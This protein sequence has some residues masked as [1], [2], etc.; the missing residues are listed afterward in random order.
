MRVTGDLPILQINFSET[1]Y[2]A[3]MAAI[4]DVLETFNDDTPVVSSSHNQ[5]SANGEKSIQSALWLSGPLDSS[6]MSTLRR[7][8]E[9]D[10]FY[11]AVERPADIVKVSTWLRQGLSVPILTTLDSSLQIF[12][13]RRN[14]SHSAS[15]YRNC[16]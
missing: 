10:E 7:T 12:N 4:D 8:I 2:K 13:D 15:K 11:D 14:C 1:K 9:D 3:M 6:R 5:I 16:L